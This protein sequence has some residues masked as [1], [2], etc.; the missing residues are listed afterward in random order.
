MELV[1]EQHVD[2]ET[3][4]PERIRREHAIERVRLTIDDRLSR[5]DHLEPLRQRRR[6]PYHRRRFA[7]DDARLLAVARGTVDL[8]T[9]LIVA[10]ETVEGDAREGR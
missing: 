10:D 8:G 9:R 5:V 6:C 1:E 3:L 7:I 4:G 2:I